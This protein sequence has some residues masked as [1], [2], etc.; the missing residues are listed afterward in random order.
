MKRALSEEEIKWAYEQWC[1]G[2][3]KKEIADAL[4]V[5]VNTIDGYFRQRKLKKKKPPL[6]PPKKMC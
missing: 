5:H 3:S 4:F 1:Q 6:T 2:Y